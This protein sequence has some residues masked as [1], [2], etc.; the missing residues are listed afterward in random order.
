MT[1]SAK[2]TRSPGPDKLQERYRYISGLVRARELLLLDQA[3]LNRL[4]EDSGPDAITRLLIANG[5]PAGQ[6]PEVCLSKESEAVLAWLDEQMPDPRYADTLILFND[7]HNLKLVLKKLLTQWVGSRSAPELDKSSS[8]SAQMPDFSGADGV[9]PFGEASGQ[10]LLPSRV[11]AAV[12]YRQIAMRE[13][14][15]LPKWL[16][17]LS[18]RAIE[19]YLQRYDFSD[20]DHLI[21]QAVWQKVH[22]QAAEIGNRFFSAYLER[23]TDVTNLEL[24][25]RTRALRMGKDILRRALLGGGS[26]ALEA[27]LA[28]YDQS[29][30]Q[31]RALY[32]PTSLA[33]LAE[34]CRTYGQP[35]EAARFSLASDNLIMDHIRQARW[36]L[37][38]PEIPLAWALA[39]QMEIKNI[40][41]IT[42]YLRNGLP[43]AQMRDL[44][45]DSYLA[46]R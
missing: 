30:D 22:A 13:T 44:I 2:T 19:R 24:L 38:G 39:R 45:R 31:V 17:D 18:V 40:R 26:L 7:A 14:G 8:G 15:E 43:R 42:T 46:W 21:D 35:G 28:V 1:A 32:A 23:R 20:I 37:N 16:A 36:V 29:E 6:D 4:T 33:A 11:P 41:I 27:V 9:L 5:Y 10:A 34:R 3:S 25:L 12:L